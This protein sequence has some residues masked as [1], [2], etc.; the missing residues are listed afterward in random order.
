MALDAFASY[1]SFRLP[2]AS[3]LLRTACSPDKDLVLLIS[4]QEHK[5]LLTLWKIQGVRRWEVAIENTRGAS[6]DIVAVVWSPDGVS[7]N[8]LRHLDSCSL[9]LYILL[10]GQ[11]FGLAHEPPCVTLHSIHDGA[12]MRN[13]AVSQS[14]P[15][16]TLVNPRITGMW[17]FKEEKS[18]SGTSIPDILKHGPAVVSYNP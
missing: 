12:E 8:D 15:H 1:A 9:P 6:S 7:I 14:N 5:L 10:T 18:E 2:A 17:W 13:L 11:I 4:S 16:T 3:T